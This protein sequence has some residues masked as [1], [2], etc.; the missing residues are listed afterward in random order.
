MA[1]T[2]KSKKRNRTYAEKPVKVLEEVHNK[3]ADF[4]KYQEFLH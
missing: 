1:V 2:I 4:V 3:L